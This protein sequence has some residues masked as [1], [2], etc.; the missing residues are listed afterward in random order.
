MRSGNLSGASI[1]ALIKLKEA[2]VDDEEEE[3]SEDKIKQDEKPQAAQ[4]ANDKNKWE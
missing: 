1:K 2:E 4:N 3:N